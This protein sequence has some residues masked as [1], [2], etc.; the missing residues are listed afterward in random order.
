DTSAT[1]ESKGSTAAPRLP[2]T[3]TKPT[4]DGKPS[5]AT[6]AT[7]ATVDGL[8]AI[9]AVADVV[10]AVKPAGDETLITILTPA[11][12]LSQ[13]NAKEN[14]TP[15]KADDTETTTGIAPDAGVTLTQSIATPVP[16]TIVVTIVPEVA[17][18]P[19]PAPVAPANPNDSTIIV[20]PLG[21]GSA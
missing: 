21:A 18:G 8:P 16:A 6:L 17:Q 10:V 1:T 12:A 11:A 2:K 3:A 5:D 7:T 9:A 20:A 15:A 19:S 14:K 13:A 4:D